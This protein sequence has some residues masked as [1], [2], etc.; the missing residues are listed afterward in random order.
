MGSQYTGI[1]TECVVGGWD[2]RPCSMAR[3]GEK[4]DGTKQ[5]MKRYKSIVDFIPHQSHRKEKLERNENAR[6]E[7][8]QSKET[9]L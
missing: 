9:S 1:I 6:N 2:E 4:D 7:V 3:R 8:N 5:Q